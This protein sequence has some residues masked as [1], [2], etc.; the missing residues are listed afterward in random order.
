MHRPGSCTCSRPDLFAL[1]HLGGAARSLCRGQSDTHSDTQEVAPSVVWEKGAVSLQRACA[2]VTVLQY[3]SVL[4]HVAH[5]A[6][7]ACREM[8]GGETGDGGG[9]RIL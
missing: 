9:C 2:C 8:E 5:E 1:F 3:C 7:G 4:R 6:Q